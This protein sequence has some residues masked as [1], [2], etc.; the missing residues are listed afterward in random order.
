MDCGTTAALQQQGD[1]DRSG[2]VE[3]KSLAPEEC[4]PT[5]P[6]AAAPSSSASGSA[7]SIGL[8]STT[9][10]ANVQAGAIKSV[11][12][13][14]GG[15]LK[16]TSTSTV[17]QTGA[18]D[19]GTGD[20]GEG[21]AQ[22]SAPASA[23]GATTSNL[24]S[25]ISTIAVTVGGSNEAP[26]TATSEN[27][28]DVRD[29]GIAVA[30]TAPAPAG[31]VTPETAVTGNTNAPVTGAN[32]VTGD[33][34]TSSPQAAAQCA[35]ANAAA[36]KIEGKADKTLS[37]PSASGQPIS[38][39]IGQ[40]ARVTNVGTS[41]G[42]SAAQAPRASNGGT[43]GP[44]T[45]SGETGP[46]PAA[47]NAA[48]AGG[49]AGADAQGLQSTNTVDNKAMVDVTIKGNNY[50]PINI[51][52]KTV[53][54]IVN[55]AVA[56]VQTAAGGDPTAS[57]STGAGAKI[58]ND[59]RLDSTAVVDVAGDNHS[60]IKIV[61]DIGAELWNK[62]MALVGLGGGSAEATADGLQV[63]NLLSLLGRASVHI[64]GDNY[65]PIDIQILLHNLIYNEG[66]AQ[67]QS[68]AQTA[69]R[70]AQNVAGTAIDT[71]RRLSSGA[72]SCLSLAGSTAVANSQIA[73]VRMPANPIV[74]E[75]LAGN[76]H[77]VDVQGLGAAQCTT[78]NAEN[79]SSGDV[80]VGEAT[81]VLTV[82]TTQTADTS[83]KSESDEDETPGDG[84]GSGG[85]GTPGGGHGAGNG[86]QPVEVVVA[87]TTKPV[88]SPGK[89][90][91]K[92]KK[93]VRNE[94]VWEWQVE[95]VPLYVI[96]PNRPAPARA[97]PE[98][99]QTETT[100]SM[101][102]AYTAPTEPFVQTEPNANTG[103]DLVT[104]LGVAL[105]ALLAFVLIRILRRRLAL[106]AARKSAID[107]PELSAPELIALPSGSVEAA[108]E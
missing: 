32:A 58:A 52:I 49:S 96:Y 105:L 19:A 42:A 64:D 16:N 59:V 48:P 55:N 86:G 18:A 36:N 21:A 90:A 50:A 74:G 82:V 7:T 67:A 3:S 72:A 107:S 77:I 79:G 66:L 51:A 34:T 53:T 70:T 95:W 13:T 91:N 68:L 14:A 94:D 10:L 5:S 9:A 61:L 33:Q 93:V 108:A 45:G 31:S 104:Q 1:A 4:T 11:G 39:N 106:A 6:A 8:I 26:I 84:D 27:Q 43:S 40:Q 99:P 15:T 17:E 80:V 73:N 65:A 76:T 71:A 75:V 38:I 24:I 100:T 103:L 101:A 28:R 97:A 54:T 81:T 41:N 29:T 20:V 60:P 23:L 88:V 92:G 30:G 22:G 89:V 87:V 62:G 85:G 56:L 57:G 12:G 47:Q 98:A 35:A 44:A 37:V 83:A 25:D 102:G 63:D 2:S 69:P 78:G 46:A